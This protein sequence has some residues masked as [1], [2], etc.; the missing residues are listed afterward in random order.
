M[1]D[2]S[3]IAIDYDH[4]KEKW[5]ESFERDPECQEH[6]L[7]DWLQDM[8]SIEECFAIGDGAKGWAFIPD[9]HAD[10]RLIS[11]YGV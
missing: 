1:P 2:R 10:R 5:R 8:A 4:E 6:E 9:V 3:P 7:L 11:R